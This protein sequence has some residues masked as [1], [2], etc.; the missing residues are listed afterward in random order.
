M[1]YNSKYNGW[2]NLSNYLLLKNLYYFSNLISHYD[3]KIIGIIY[4]IAYYFN[5]IVSQINYYNIY[6][7]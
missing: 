6:D 5:K 3:D 4:K 7:I 2:L 1:T